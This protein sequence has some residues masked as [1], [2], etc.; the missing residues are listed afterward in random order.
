[1][2]SFIV[3]NRNLGQVCDDLCNQIKKIWSSDVGI[4][5]VDCST[6]DSLASTSISI[7]VETKEAILSGLRF[8]RGMNIGIT[9]LLENGI[10]NEWMC[11]VPV[12]TEILQV[13][14]SK[15]ISDLNLIKDLVA[16]KPL[17]EGSPYE[18]LV[19]PEG[20]SLGWN[21]EEGPWIIKTSFI[22]EQVAMSKDGDF[23]DSQNFRGYLTSLEIAFRAY[24]NGKC[25]G[26]TKNLVVREN[27]DHLLEKAALI[28]TEPMEE[29]QNLLLSEGISW[30]NSKY[31]I[32]DPW[33]FA[34]LVRLLYENYLL[35]NPGKERF[36]LL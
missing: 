29:N 18:E 5:V 1:M 31:K 27:E 3:L 30:L 33:S 12:D 34:Q 16:V 9:Y 28:A 22:K 17:S 14:P 20:I 35:E 8:N 4:V 23:F 21:F 11:L 13:D 24:A 10:E 25:I 32:S 36:R 2:I 26:I 6:S 15:L 7:R 19:S